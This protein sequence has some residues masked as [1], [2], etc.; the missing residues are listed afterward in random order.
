MADFI[1]TASLDEQ[2]SEKRAKHPIRSLRIYENTAKIRQYIDTAGFL[3][4]DDL[5]ALAANGH[6]KPAFY[7]ATR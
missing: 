7:R 4:V 1:L 3:P 5:F 6:L 2:S